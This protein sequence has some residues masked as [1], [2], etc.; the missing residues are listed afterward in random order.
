MCS[1]YPGFWCNISNNNAFTEDSKFKYLA[2]ILSY[3]E[4]TDIV[5]INNFSEHG[6]IKDF[7]EQNKYTLGKICEVPANRLCTIIDLLDLYFVDI[8]IEN[9]DSGVLEHIFSKK[10]YKLNVEMICRFCEYKF[11]ERVQDLKTANYTTLCQIA[12][13]PVMEYVYDDFANYVT[14]FILAQESNTCEH[15][16][17]CIK[18]ANGKSCMGEFYFLLQLL[19]NVG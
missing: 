13:E 4:E 2:L 17:S 15:L 7:I 8:N 5:K 3:A 16:E 9:V 6:N 10:K 11:P 18:E 14:E 1:Y 19:W 12:Y